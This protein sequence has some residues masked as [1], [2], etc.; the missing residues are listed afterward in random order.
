MSKVIDLMT[1]ERK[2]TKQN[3]IRHYLSKGKKALKSNN[4]L[5]MKKIWE[6]ASDVL[7]VELCDFC[8]QDDFG[9]CGLR[10][11][12]ISDEEKFVKYCFPAL[13]L[14]WESEVK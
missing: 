3:A 4:Y 8:I 7:D 11:T 14:R 9:Y 13:I 1:G 6:D 2:M 12:N 10:K 5:L